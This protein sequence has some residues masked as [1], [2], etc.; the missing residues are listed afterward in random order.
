[1]KSCMIMFAHYLR[2]ALLNSLGN[3]RYVGLNVLCL[4]SAGRV[5]VKVTSLLQLVNYVLC[6]EAAGIGCIGPPILTSALDRSE[7]SASRHGPRKH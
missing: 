3:M 1:M 4:K 6:H 2:I 5:I 7:W